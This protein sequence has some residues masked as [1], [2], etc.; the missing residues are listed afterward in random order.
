MSDS[1]LTA[2]DADM[3]TVVVVG[4]GPVGMVAALKLGKL[5]YQV[6]VL[7]AGDDLAE[8]SRASTFHPSSL[9]L[10]EELGVVDELRAVGLE[11]PVFQ[12]RE[13]AG[14]VLSEMDMSLLAGETKYPFRLQSE[15]N[16]LTHII[17][18]HLETMPN[19][20]LQFSS[21][22]GRVEQ[23]FEHVRIFLPDTDRDHPIR[24]RW[25]VA[26]DGAQSNIRKSLGISFEG[27]TYDERFLVIST[28]HEF[29]DDFPDLAYVS[30]ISDPEE[31]GVL[32]RTPNHW[33]ALFPVQDDESD[34]SAL[35][36]D[37]MEARLQ[38]IAPQPSRYDVPHASIYKVNMRAAATFAS[39]HILLAGDAAHVNNPLGGMGMNSGIH[40]AWAAAEVIDAAL[41]GTDSTHAASLY[42][43]LRRDAALNHVQAQAQK[44]YDSMSEDDDA[45]REARADMLSAMDRDLLDKR[46]HLRTAAMFTSLR[47]TMGRLARELRAVPAATRPAGRRLSEM[48]CYE[49][50]LAPGAYDG[51]SAKALDASGFTAGYVS[52]AAVS[53]AAL[54]QPDLGYL[55]LAEMAE[56]VRRMTAVSDIALIVDGDTGYGGVLQVGEAVTRLE[57]AG[58]AA[59]QFEDQVAPK[60]CGHLTG[61][62][63]VPIEE[64]VAKIEIAS[65]RRRSALIIARTDALSV[66]GIDAALTRVRAYAAAGADLV[67]VEG[68]YSEELLRAIHDAIP[69]TPLVINVSEAGDHSALPHPRILRELGVALMIYPVAPIL[70]SAESITAMYTQIRAT[71]SS[72]LSQRDWDRFTALT[73][74]DAQLAQ[75]A[76]FAT[77]AVTH[78]NPTPS[79][80]LA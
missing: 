4:M 48:L 26:A 40:D 45:E 61:R 70:A 32:L 39:G 24:A 22:V 49:T 7:E 27:R 64:M 74:Q 11:A 68:A 56:Q 3:N 29:R 66:D 35:S 6:L 18:R 15:Q 71:R 59:I 79:R 69:G 63:V 80:S 72:G 14:A 75:S 46:D 55:G 34:E 20:T 30:Y 25:V 77:S 76:G 12:Y 47:I 62:Q 28:T 9:E 33:R 67:F 41:T 42:S 51:V 19:V 10:L 23:G 65:S 8:E 37:A 73:G 13:R 52:G 31:W 54:G 16:N 44:N 50:V 2:A 78:I 57:R 17:R 58:A 60:R 53:A 43:E 38:R 21:P 5:G 1:T 36:P